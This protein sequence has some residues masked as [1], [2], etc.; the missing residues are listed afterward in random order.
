M[1]PHVS[2][3]V[4]SSLSSIFM[5]D[6]APLPEDPVVICL[7]ALGRPVFGYLPKACLVSQVS[8]CKAGL[9]LQDSREVNRKDL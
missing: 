4:N 6:L 9:L 7:Q 3:G 1:F 8:K 5:L 2:V